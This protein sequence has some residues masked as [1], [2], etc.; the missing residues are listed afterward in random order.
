MTEILS[1]SRLGLI[2]KRSRQGPCFSSRP[3]ADSDILIIGGF[4]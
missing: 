2:K 4:Y 1:M 3:G